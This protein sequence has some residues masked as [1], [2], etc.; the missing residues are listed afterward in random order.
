MKKSNVQAFQLAAAVSAAVF[1]SSNAFA[2]SESSWPNK[3]I[4]IIVAF[5]AGGPIDRVARVI[6]PVLQAELEVPVIVDNKPGASGII[7]QQYVMN[8]R[9]EHTIM[10]HTTGGHSVR[11]HTMKLNFDPWKT[12]LPV[13]AVASIPTLY[14]GSAK[15]R[16]KTIPDLVNFGKQNP[17]KI[18]FGIIGGLGT[19]NH[20]AAEMF[21]DSQGIV[22]TNVPYNS[23]PQAL[24]ALVT[25][26]VDVANA[27]LPVA[28]P[29]IQ[30]GKLVAYAVASEKRSRYLP[31]V[32]TTAEAGMP[33]VLNSDLCAIF[34][35]IGMPPARIKKLQLAVGNA[36]KD[37]AV[38][39]AFNSSMFEPETRTPEE[40]LKYMR[41]ENVRV[42]ALVAAHDI[43]AE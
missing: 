11:P 25:G 33:G 43:R 21:K 27:Y 32:P 24:P 26:E 37:N 10:L 13:A 29:Q 1:V 31:A 8:S 3:P 34:V 18:N 39:E 7:A 23:W 15:S 5:A 20:V 22:T 19:T 4:Q 14:V 41:D 42:G 40:L 2:Q 30:A 6:A 17:G 36:L 16:W 9:D 35:P 38:R 12:L 28:V